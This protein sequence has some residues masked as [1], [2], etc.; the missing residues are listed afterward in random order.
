[1]NAL[2]TVNR[3]V[4]WLILWFFAYAWFSDF[5]VVSGLLLPDLVKKLISD[6]AGFVA[7]PLAVAALAVP[8]IVAAVVFIRQTKAIKQNSFSV[9]KA[10]LT[11]LGLAGGGLGVGLLVFL[12]PVGF[13]ALMGSSDLNPFALI[14]HTLVSPFWVAS[15]I[16]FWLGLVVHTRRRF[17]TP[18][19]EKM[20]FAALFALAVICGILGLMGLAT[21][22]S[23]TPMG[24]DLLGRILALAISA[25]LAFKAA[26]YTYVLLSKLRQNKR[27]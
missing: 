18:S 16:Y 5:T 1:M 9:K 21:G 2:L 14:L 26:F 11:A 23:S 4:N 22:L 12:T 20:S 24:G 15:S 10:L 25:G 3:V 17:A 7:N 8:I 27:G 19:P 13:G 6:P